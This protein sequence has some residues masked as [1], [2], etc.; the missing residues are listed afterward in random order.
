MDRVLG[1]KE[2]YTCYSDFRLLDRVQDWLERKDGE[3]EIMVGFGFCLAAVTYFA[4]RLVQ[5]LMQ[6]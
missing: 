3:L 2:E 4:A 5:A 1:V 6:W